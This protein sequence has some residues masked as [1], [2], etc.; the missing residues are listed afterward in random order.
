[1]DAFNAIKTM[2]A[3]RDYQAE[4][5]PVE[6]VTRIV[7]AARL[8]GSSR[9]QQ[10]WD[11]V[12]SQ[13][14]QTL[15][16]LGELAPTGP[17]IA[18]APLAIAVVVPENPTGYIDGARAAQDMMLAAWAEG[19]GSNWVGNVNTDPIKRLLDIPQDRLV[20]TI[21]PFGYPTR[22]LGRG[23]KARKPLREIAHQEKFSRPYSDQ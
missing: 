10:H 13:D 19:V 1:M 14:P 4:P 23:R 12:V 21:I 18:R 7:E 16:K 20:L 8:T 15:K 9:N 5:I 22:K 6:L 2:L 17:Y 11:F 3:V